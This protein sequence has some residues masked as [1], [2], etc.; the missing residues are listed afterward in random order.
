MLTKK[1]NPTI[2]LRSDK[3]PAA[4]WRAPLREYVRECCR[5]V[6][7]KDRPDVSVK[8][9][10]LIDPLL[11]DEIPTHTLHWAHSPH[12]IGAPNPVER[13]GFSRHVFTKAELGGLTER[14][15]LIARFVAEMLRRADP[16]VNAWV[17]NRLRPR[18]PPSPEPE[19]LELL[20]PTLR[21]EAER[22]AIIDNLPLARRLR[23]I[24]VGALIWTCWHAWAIDGVRIASNGPR[25]LSDAGNVVGVGRVRDVDH[26]RICAKGCAGKMIGAMRELYGAARI[27]SVQTLVD[28]ITGERLTKEELLRLAGGPIGGKAS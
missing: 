6:E 5:A 4:W 22:R 18:H 2:F 15:E 27:T 17:A 7:A 28:A 10:A 11:A 16:P 8:L 13:D 26:R 12:I 25:N 20:R 24:A 9:R 23:L 3:S 19:L 1:N 14:R 21:I